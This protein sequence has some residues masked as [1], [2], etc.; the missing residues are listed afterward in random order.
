[1]FIES[2]QY[3]QLE[4]FGIFLRLVGTIQNLLNFD[5]LSSGSPERVLV[6]LGVSS[7]GLSTDFEVI[8]VDDVTTTCKKIPELPE[9]EKSLAPEIQLK[10][11]VRKK[12]KPS[13]T[14]VPEFLDMPQSP[15]VFFR[16]NN[17]NPA[18]CRKD[19]CFQFEDNVWQKIK[20]PEMRRFGT[21]PAISLGI[22]VRVQV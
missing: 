15:A 5:D 16:M 17:R 4:S 21:F 20:S 1:M 9:P 11:K 19:D 3:Q 18:I 13:S 14:F 7:E 2:I 22:W 6:G 12:W 8:D 10:S